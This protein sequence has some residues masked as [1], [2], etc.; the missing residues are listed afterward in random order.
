MKMDQW[1]LLH[2]ADQGVS[3]LVWEKSWF[4]NQLLC[5]LK[6]HV[7]VCCGHDVKALDKDNDIE[8]CIRRVYRLNK[9]LRKDEYG[10]L[11]ERRRKKYLNF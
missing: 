10:Y 1:Q 5:R 6:S 4:G 2:N 3:L 8:S 9:F 7:S 11:V